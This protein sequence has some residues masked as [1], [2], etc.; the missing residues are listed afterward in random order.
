V[1]AKC[2]VDGHVITSQGPGTSLQFALK[3]VEKLYGREKAETQAAA[4]LTTLAD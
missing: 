2:V 3:M 4:L 1:D